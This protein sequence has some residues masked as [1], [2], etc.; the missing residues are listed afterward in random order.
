MHYA[1][2]S[3]RDW[4][5]QQRE[6]TRLRRAEAKAAYT[7]ERNNGLYREERELSPQQCRVFVAFLWAHYSSAALPKVRFTYYPN[8]SARGG[9]S[10]II[11]PLWG[12]NKTTICHEVAHALTKQVRGHCPEWKRNYVTL[13]SASKLR[14]KRELLVSLKIAKLEVAPASQGVKRLQRKG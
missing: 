10:D 11:L 2:D 1:T 12:R 13:L 6:K 3:M 4:H 8:A 7:W 5:R 14:S 9:H